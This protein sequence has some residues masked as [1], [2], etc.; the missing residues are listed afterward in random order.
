MEALNR[1]DADDLTSRLHLGGHLHRLLVEGSHGGHGRDDFREEGGFVVVIQLLSSLES[2]SPQHRRKRALSLA[3]GD[4]SRAETDFTGDKKV[5]PDPAAETGGAGVAEDDDDDPEIRERLRVEIFKLALSILSESMQQHPL[6][7][8]AFDETVGWKH[9]GSSIVLS[10]IGQ[11]SPDHLFGSLLGLCM[12]DVS[13]YSGRIDSLRREIEKQAAQNQATGE[14]DAASGAGAEA[15]IAARAQEVWSAPIVFPNASLLVLE[16]IQGL[17]RN[18]PLL[19]KMVAGILERMATSSKRNQALLAGTGLASRL[20]E[21]VLR[22]DGSVDEGRLSYLR[23]VRHL[24]ALGIPDVDGRKI[25]RNL[26][27]SG[28][29]L[30]QNTLLDLLLDVSPLSRERN[31]ITFTMAEYG[32]ASVAFST[33][34]RPFPP[35][36]DSRGFTFVTSFC[37]DR[38]EPSLPLELLH[39]FDAH[40]TCS[41]RLTIEPGTG[42]LTYSTL[43]Q[44]PPVRFKAFQFVPGRLY[45]IVFAHSRPRGGAKSSLV[46]LFVDG[47]LIEEKLAPWPPSPPNLGSPVRAV[48]G[49]PPNAQARM[50]GEMG[51]SHGSGGGRINRLVWSLGPTWLLDDLL[52]VDMPLVLCE[53]GLRYSGNAQDSLGRFLTYRASAQINL[54][55]DAVARSSG[56][57]AEKELARHPLV[58]AVAAKSSELVH[59]DRFYFVLNAANTAQLERLPRRSAPEGGAADPS[60]RSSSTVILNQALPMTREAIGAS[61]GFA[62]LYGDPVLLMPKGTDELVWRLGGSSVLLQLIDASTTALALR[63]TLSLFFDLVSSSWRLS[64]DVERSKGYEV[65]GHLLRSKAHI[66]EPATLELLLA[67]IGIDFAYIEQSVLV[68]P[69]L[70]RIIMLDFELWSQTSESMQLVHLDHFKI[71]LR[72]SRHRRFN[73][74]RVAKMQIP[75]KIVY[76]LRSRVYGTTAAQ[77]LVVALRAVLNSGFTDASIRIVTSYLATEL[78][79]GPEAPLAKAPIARRSNT[80]VAGALDSTDTEGLS[81]RLSAGSGG[82]AAGS[83]SSGGDEDPTVPL[84]VFEMLSELVLEKPAYLQKFA[85]A[86]NVKWLLLFF[87]PRAERRAV[88]LALELLV[89]LLNRPKLGFAERFTAA[90]GFKVMERLLP[91]FWSTPMTLSLLW[92]TLFGMDGAGVPALVPT[93]SP[94]ADG[95]AERT[96]FCPPAMRAILSCAK[97]GLRS[98][99]LRGDE[100]KRRAHFQKGRPSDLLEPPTSS[101]RPR[102]ARKRSQSMNVDVKGLQEAFKTSNELGVLQETLELVRAHAS[103]SHFFREVLFSPIVLRGLIDAIFPF[104][105]TDRSGSDLAGHGKLA[106]DVAELCGPVLDMLARL[107]VD[108][109][110]STRST[111]IVSALTTALPPTDLARQASFRTSLYA[112]ITVHLRSAIQQTPDVARSA[113]EALA[114][115]IEKASE[116]ILNGSPLEGALFGIIVDLLRLLDDRPE[117]SQS[118]ATSLLLLS[119]N[120]ILLH[121][122]TLDDRILATL[123]EITE[124]QSLVFL[125]ANKDPTFFECLGNRVLYYL[126]TSTD[127]DV[128]QLA[129]NLLKLMTLSR[130]TVVESILADGKT[131]PDLLGANTSTVGEMLRVESPQGD[132]SAYPYQES[133][134]GFFKSRETLKAAAHLERVQQ[135]HEMLKRVDTREQAVINTESRMVAWHASL[136]EAEQAR[137]AKFASDAREMDAFAATEWRGLLAGLERERALLAPADGGLDSTEGPARVR[138]KLQ[139]LPLQEK[140]TDEAPYRPESTVGGDTMPSSPI[141]LGHGDEWG[142]ADAGAL[143]LSPSSGA[144]ALPPAPVAP[145]HHRAG[146]ATT[147]SE[148]FNPDAQPVSNAAATAAAAAATAASTSASSLHDDGAGESGESH[149]EDKYRRVLRSLER[150]DII[151]AVYNTSRVVGIESRGCLLILGRTSIYLMDDYF[152]RPNGELINVWEAPPEERDTLVMATLSSDASRPSGLIAQLEGDAQTR[153]WPWSAVQICHRRSWLHRRTAVEIFFEDGQSCLLVCRQTVTAQ[154]LYQELRQRAPSAV[155]AAEAMREGIREGTSGASGGGGNSISLGSR[156]AG[157]VLGRTQ[158]C[159]ALTAAWRDGRISNFAYLMDLNTL[160]GRSMNDLTQFPCFPWVLADYHSVELDLTDPATF[161]KFEL[162]MGAQTAQRR[163]EFE[164]RF[165]Q[166]VEVD[167]EPFHYGTHYS[168]AA[169][170]C[171]FLIR[172]RPFERLYMALQGGNFDLA[173]RTFSSIGKAW[174]SA[175]EL[176]RGDVRELIPEFFYLPEFLVNSNRFE[177]GVTQ[178]GEVIDDVELPPWAKGDPLLFVQKHREALECEYVSQRL[179]SWVDLVFGYR[180]RGAEA[181]ESTNVFH[182]LSYEDAVD[183]DSIESSMERQ[184]VAQVIHNFGQTP[185]RLFSQPH[186]QRSRSEVATLPVGERFGVLEHPLLLIQSVAPIRSLKNAV[187]FIYPHHPE[188]AFASPRDYL[189]LPHLGVSLSLGHLDGS[190]RMFG[191]R[192]AKRPLAVVEQ[193]TAERITCIAQARSK[194]FIAGSAD[195]VVSVWTV[196]TAARELTLANVLRGH[197]RSV[198]CV[199][200]SSAWSIAVS[201]SQDRTAIVW[202]LNR[203]SYVRT[204]RGHDVGVQHVAIDDKVGCIATAYGPGVRLWSINGELLA[205]VATSASILEPISSLAFYERDYHVGRLAV[206]LTGHRGK[207]VAW[208]A[209]FDDDGHDVGEDGRRT[210]SRH[211]LKS[212]K[213]TNSLGAGAATGTGG[214]G[215]AAQQASE[216]HSRSRS[217]AGGSGGGSGSALPPMPSSK[218]KWKLERFHVLQHQERLGAAADATSTSTSTSTT[219]TTLTTTMTAPLITAI[220]STRRMV[221]TGDEVGRLY[222]WTLTGDAVGVPDGFSSRCMNGGCGRRFGVL[223]SRRTCG[224]CGGLFCNGC[225]A[226]HRQFATSIRFCP[227]CHAVVDSA[228]YF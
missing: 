173:D 180:S 107:A 99:A 218:T 90:G 69:F 27:E 103:A 128:R 121:R 15:V 194:A 97:E 160:A 86:I 172:T 224:G 183:L 47:L 176:S 153:K 177:F 73:A 14:G 149:H 217:K 55:L 76:A 24:L 83:G 22:Q 137:F 63:K 60:Y 190:V 163:R 129:F 148:S 39:I 165:G 101:D 193:L 38:I 198:L 225:A 41:A 109:M 17:G 216:G 138:L 166:L 91:R 127:E 206:L 186:P 108:S 125:D 70:Y 45:H 189:I 59:E 42:L 207:V 213:S 11:T 34:R 1:S 188:K 123:T 168:T 66:L 113:T 174:A 29:P 85:E 202:D 164:E 4:V 141:E 222:L 80:L 151:E 74:K 122:L 13:T 200:A 152:Q 146:G 3:R 75:K 36:P 93:F 182:P 195:G 64:E 92:S 100:P 134:D 79:R 145:P 43:H 204:L 67:A 139:Q 208:Q 181:V 30:E 136:C 132:G 117:L 19:S 61:Y 32:H 210:G 187:H 12:G 58:M 220:S 23:I 133:W 212:S 33:L 26:V 111:A 78:C 185:S 226:H 170:V 56:A 169:T 68:N 191:A 102:H 96:I 131:A 116:D 72:T 203:G 155:S 65:L 87:H 192:D 209:V 196:D 159:G 81:Q 6:N 57:K 179:H 112:D 211:G 184:A 50:S 175:S 10:T 150:G 98:V 214:P 28:V 37:I 16:M 199:A 54:R 120:R 215:E 52:P 110:L 49:S 162:P 178:A 154:K 158:Q 89:K 77:T 130:P 115:F 228:P 221:L 21:L 31:S 46:Q 2:S 9:L 147:T 94:A 205:S 8:K 84:Q 104:V 114:E 18:D 144:A 143:S 71:L 135:L 20:L 161:R 88:S 118:R 201:G 124:A 5:T 227:S 25:F 53:L 156:L 51:G 35:G 142:S 48:L 62:K 167:M 40:R 44:P 95:G 197:D 105:G 106:T 7:V 157:A 126:A 223:E 219:S 140:E 171:G 82:D 119:L